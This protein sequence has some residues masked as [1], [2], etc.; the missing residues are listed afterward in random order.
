[1]S[2]RNRA[3]IIG[4]M[5]PAIQATG[6]IWQ[7]LHFYVYHL[8]DGLTVRHLLF[9]PGFLMVLV[10]F[11]VSL[12]CVPLATEVAAA[13]PDDLEIP[14][15]GEDDGMQSGLRLPGAGGATTLHH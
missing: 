9:E 14:A 3:L 8:H 4:L 13:R 7:A 5:G 10:G 2:V 12:V 6:F 1:M 15:F 11:L